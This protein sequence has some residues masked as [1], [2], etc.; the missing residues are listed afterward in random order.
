MTNPDKNVLSYGSAPPL[1]RCRRGLS[2]C[3]ASG[4]AICAQIAIAAASHAHWLDPFLLYFVLGPL[5]ALLLVP[6]AIIS[7]AVACCRP[8][9]RPDALTLA[10]VLILAQLAGWLACV[11]LL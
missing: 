7:A 3:V 1:A 2:S 4:L 6:A 9:T 11:V 8:P 5:I 10:T